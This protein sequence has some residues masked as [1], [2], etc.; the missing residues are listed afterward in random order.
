[1]N[2]LPPLRPD[3]WALE[4]V[5]GS[6]LRAEGQVPPLGCHVGLT[7]QTTRLV[8]IPGRW[9]GPQWEP[10]VPPQDQQSKSPQAPRLRKRDVKDLSSKGGW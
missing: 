2:P 1:M 3:S 5:V 8:L 6:W 4:E 9:M 7:T 10:I